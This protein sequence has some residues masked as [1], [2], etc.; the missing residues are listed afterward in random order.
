[1][2]TAGYEV[3]MGGGSFRATKEIVR[4]KKGMCLPLGV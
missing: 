4:N 3:G 2:R 1:M